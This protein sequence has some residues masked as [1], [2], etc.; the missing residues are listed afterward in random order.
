[1]S[2]S[3][4]LRQALL[5]GRASVRLT[6]A[7]CSSNGVSAFELAQPFFADERASPAVVRDRRLGICRDDITYH[8]PRRNGSPENA[9]FAAA[10]N[11]REPRQQGF[12][13]R[14]A[15]RARRERSQRALTGARCV[16]DHSIKQ[17]AIVRALSVR[18]PRPS[19][20]HSRRQGVET[21]GQ[22]GNHHRRRERNR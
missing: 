9:V 15:L 8:S 14:G 4:V 11:P 18:S 6:T 16:A 5:R 22:G 10:R 1:M 12:R 3:R 13:I 2:A 20:M 21:A 19:K 17:R 7:H